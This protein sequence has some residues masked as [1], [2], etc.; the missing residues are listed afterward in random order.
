MTIDCPDELFDKMK[1][2][3]AKHI[4]VCKEINV[5]FLPLEAQVSLSG[6]SF[7]L[8]WL[9]LV[10]IMTVC[11]LYGSPVQVFSCDNKEAFESIYNPNSQDRDQTLERIADQIVTLC[12]TLDEYPGVR[13]KR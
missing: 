11:V 7:S 10:L 4:K 6:D 9:S 5:S 13:Y 2:N 12:A 1:K 8:L 3:C